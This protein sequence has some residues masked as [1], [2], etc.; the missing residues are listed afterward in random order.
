MA[1][2][3]NLDD[4]P[5]AGFERVAGR[6]GFVG[7]IELVGHRFEQVA[8]GAL[9][10][11]EQMAGGHAGA[12]DGR[13][14][15]PQRQRAVLGAVVIGGKGLE[16]IAEVGGRDLRKHRAA[17]YADFGVG[18]FGGGGQG[19]AGGDAG[20]EQLTRGPFANGEPLAAEFG[21]P[22]GDLVRVGLGTDRPIESPGGSC[23][24]GGGQSQP[25]RHAAC[26]VCHERINANKSRLPPTYEA[27]LRAG[28]GQRPGRSGRGK[29]LGLT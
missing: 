2:G 6:I 29:G 15:I 5:A 22:G 20:L 1:G 28:S 26:Q 13:E 23:H 4:G 19:V 14:A 3:G 12:K 10:L 25:D 21:D 27:I 8:F 24:D 18:S 7:R 16:P 11:D 9:H 17:A